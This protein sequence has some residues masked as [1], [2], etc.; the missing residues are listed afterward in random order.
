MIR[1]ALRYR[2]RRQAERRAQGIEPGERRGLYSFCRGLGQLTGALSDHLGPRVH[3]AESVRAIEKRDGAITVVT[4][5]GAFPAS[6]VV[7]A[8][9]PHEAARLVRGMDA[10][11][12]GLLE[13][14]PMS[15]VAVVH[16]GYA[17]RAQDIPDGFGFLAPRG[18][19]IE[20]LGILFPSRLFHGRAL[21]GGDVATG[22]VGGMLNV[23]ALQKDD[24]ALATIVGSELSRLTGSAVRPDLVQVTRHPSAIPQFTLGHLE[25]MGRA[26]ARLEHIPG[27]FLAGNY[28]KGVG[29]K[30]AVRSG[31]EV[32]ARIVTEI[33]SR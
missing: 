11:L 12:A 29:M 8:V 18:E 13:S 17:H 30:D 33:R 19:G 23:E 28:L 20:T 5:R 16:Q 24:R 7:L 1:G 6:R 31:F 9:P 14:I 4:G 21:D 10:A 27:L 22:Y 26:H 32:S 2:K 15:P 3:L 25:R